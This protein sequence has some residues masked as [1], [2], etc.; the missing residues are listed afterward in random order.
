LKVK[1]Y[2]SILLLEVKGNKMKKI[3]LEIKDYVIII[4]VVVLIRCFIVT[5]AVVDGDSM[6]NTLENGQVVLINKFNYLFNE[7]KRFQIVVVKTGEKH[8]K[9]I[10]RIIGL[11]NEKIVYKDN[12]LYINGELIKE[13]FDHGYTRDFETETKDGEYFVLGD[14]RE[15]SKDSRVLGNFTKKNIV[16]S[17]NFRLFPFRKFGKI[18]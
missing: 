2:T 13:E 4:L 8:D 11:P 6:D 15:V 10:K 3:L 18:E 9:I 5:P 14:N 16:G 1:K 12:E 17:V 7:P